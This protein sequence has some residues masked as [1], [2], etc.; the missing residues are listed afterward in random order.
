MQFETKIFGRFCDDQHKDLLLSVVIS[1][2]FKTV[3][4]VKLQLQA[5]IREEASGQNR[6]SQVQGLNQ[7]HAGLFFFYRK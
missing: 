2:M 4:E 5:T 7:G 1:N 6:A 3:K